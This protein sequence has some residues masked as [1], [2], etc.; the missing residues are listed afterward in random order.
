MKAAESGGEPEPE[1][2]A[3][4]EAV[5]VEEEEEEEEEEEGSQVSSEDEARA[6]GW[7]GDGVEHGDGGRDVRRQCI[8]FFKAMHVTHV[9]SAEPYEEWLERNHIPA[10]ARRMLAEQEQWS[11]AKIDAK[12]D[13]RVADFDFD[14]N[15]PSPVDE[16]PPVVD[17]TLFYSLGLLSMQWKLRRNA[18]W[19]ST[20]TLFERSFIA[21]AGGASPRRPG[22]VSPYVSPSILSRRCR[23]LRSV[24]L[25][26]SCSCGA[27]GPSSHSFS[28]VERISQPFCS[29]R[30]MM[31][32]M[33]YRRSLSML[34][35]G[36]RGPSTAASS[37]ELSCRIRRKIT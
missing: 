31:P 22:A 26:I 20:H 28:T 9:L 36:K 1:P 16:G 13:E 33:T 32:R 27:S 14:F 6:E 34:P 7:P 5:D 24:Y 8:E 21:S 29:N 17:G 3:E 12:Q 4:P 2:E 19:L 30:R 11:V 10:R 35:P 37:G 23:E 25:E 18:V 15:A